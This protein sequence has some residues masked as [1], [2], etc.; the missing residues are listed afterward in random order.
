MQK[1]EDQTQDFVTLA[2][3]LMNCSWKEVPALCP[4][5]V[6]RNRLEAWLKAEMLK[7]EIPKRKVQHHRHF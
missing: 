1:E 7:A 3:D 2:K 5:G 4:T 6:A